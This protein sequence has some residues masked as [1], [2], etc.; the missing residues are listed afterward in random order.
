M[1]EMLGNEGE[2][3]KLNCHILTVDKWELYLWGR[4]KGEWFSGSDGRE[5]LYI[6]M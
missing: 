2:E 4:T 1:G 3:A 6:V 5:E